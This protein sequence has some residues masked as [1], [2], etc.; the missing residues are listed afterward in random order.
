MDVGK[1]IVRRALRGRVRRPSGSNYAAGTKA[2]PCDHARA[3]PWRPGG[4]VVLRGGSYHESVDRRRGGSPSRTIPARPS[5]STAARGHGWSADGATWRDDSWTTRF[6]ASVGYSKGATD[7]TSAG[8]QCVNPS[9][10]MAAHPDQV[11]VDGAPLGQ[12]ASRSK[13]VAGTFYLDESTSQLYI[14]N[15]PSGKEVRAATL[16]RPCA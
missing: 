3:L 15:N 12:V 6:D 2:A 4:A 13:V 7:G 9:Y 14:G 11:C 16:A 8:W 10:P 1:A 5:G